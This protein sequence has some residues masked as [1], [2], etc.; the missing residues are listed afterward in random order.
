MFKKSFLKKIAQNEKVSLNF[1]EKQLQKGHVVIPVNSK[2]QII[3]PAIGGGFKVKVNANLGTSTERSDIN[4]ELKKLKVALECKADTIMDLSTGGNLAQIRRQILNSCPVPLGT[5]PIYEAAVKAESRHRGFEAMTFDD[6]WDVLSSQAQDG[7]DFFTI[8][9]GII[10]EFLKIIAKKKRV[11]GI[12]SRGGAIMTRWM[13]VNGRENPFYE[14]FDKI[15]D[16]A[17]QYN[18]VLS[19]G[20]A[21]RPGA[22]ADS[23]DELQISELMVLGELVKKCRRKGVQVMVEGPG[24]IRFD[25]IAFN[26]LLQKKVCNNAP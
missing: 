24:H 26:M 5:V 15:L 11:G 20:D 14:N 4:E 19:L 9:V 13:H 18:I 10:R 12:V 6:I 23:S 3:P 2:R 7:V 16:L 17:K 25:E 1:L 22:I 8:H 21:L